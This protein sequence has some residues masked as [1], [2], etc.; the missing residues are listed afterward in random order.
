MRK[1]DVTRLM[2]R[3]HGT[4]EPVAEYGR[5]GDALAIDLSAVVALG[6]AISA[7]LDSTRY[8]VGWWTHYADPDRQSRIFIS[9]YLLTCARAIPQNLLEAEVS[10]LELNHAIEDFGKWIE[11][12]ISA[13][14]FKIPPPRS[15]YD[16]LANYRVSTHLAGIFRAYA[17]ALDCLGGCVVGV[18]GLPTPIIRADIDRARNHLIKAGQQNQHLAALVKQLADLE[19]EAGPEGWSAWLSGMRNM[20]VHRGRRMVS[21]DII[22]GRGGTIDGFMLHLP[23]SPELSE[24][25]AWVHAD[26]YVAAHFSSP[27]DVFLAALSDTVLKY[28]NGVAQALVEFWTARKNDPQLVTQSPQQWKQPQGVIQPPVFLGYRVSEQMPLVTE[29]GVSDEVERRLK[30]AGL[31]QR[32]THDVGPSPTVWFQSGK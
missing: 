7:D 25:E 22:R 17:S 27:H 21:W 2:T 32:R 26:G 23:R 9:D 19:S 16:D 14:R 18:A 12:G 10:K 11:R 3:Y 4:V 20:L 30:A 31:T 1:E 8:S 15:P 29:I 5:L 13:K 6:D 28:V 24:V